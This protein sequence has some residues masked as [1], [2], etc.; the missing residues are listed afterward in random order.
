MGKDLR[1][2]VRMLRKSPGFTLMAVVALA[3]GIGANTA[4]FSIVNAVMLSR[5]PFEKPDRL[6]MVW[7]ASPSTN[8]TNVVNPL[9]FLEWQERNRS[10]ARIAA[11]APFLQ[12]SLSG[13]GEPEQ[14]D[15]MAVSSGFFEILGIQP[16][17]GRWFTPQEDTPGNDNVAILGEGLWR[18][19]YGADRGIVGH[20]IHVNNQAITVVGIMP[21]GFRFPMTKSV[22]WTPLGLDRKGATASRGRYLSTLARLRE[23][24]SVVTAQSDMN[25]I[26]SQLQKERPDFDSKW[27]ITVISLR[28]QVVGDVRKPLYI[29]LGAVGLVLM[30]ACANVANLMLMRAAGRGR[31]IAIRTALGAGRLRIVRQLLV[32]STLLSTAGGALGLVAGLWSMSALTA[33]LP[34]SIAYLNLKAIRL[35]GTV[36]LFTL[37]LS[38]V[39]G[40]LFGLAPAIKAARTDIQEALKS[41]GRGI[42]S[43]RSFTRSALVV[44]EVALSMILLVSAGLLIRSFARLAN[45]D[46][47]FDA[48]HVLTMHLA[49]AG[50]FPSDQK[51]AEFNLQVLQRVRAVPGVEAAGAA[52]FLPLGRIIPGT[53]FWRADHIRPAP[54]DAPVAEVLVVMPGYFAA[55]NIP[56]LQGRVF[57]DHDRAAQQPHL[58]VI[59]QTLAKQFYPNESPVGKRLSVQWGH[60]NDPYEIAGVVGDVHEKSLDADPKPGVFVA[61]L[62]EPNGFSNLVVRTHGDPK[63]LAQAIQRE[64]HALD[65]DIPISDVKTMDEDVAASVAAPRFNT[66]LLAG[67][68]GLALALSAVG[69]FGVISYSVAQRTQELG[70]RRA[71]GANSCSMMRLVLVE[72]LG[73]AGI[74]LAIG[75]AGA[76]AV[77]RLLE[78]LL[79]GVTAT[80]PL[81]FGVV[82]AILALVALLA[83]YLPARRAAA[84]D[85]IVALRYE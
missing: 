58:V 65:H 19:R 14:V 4:I 73:L 72:G 26:S 81:T 51:F 56:V 85:P 25:L 47:G 15:G 6:A 79:F 50:R 7:E 3:L 40:M 52:Q 75:L 77:T 32:E 57:D 69:I 41:G 33:A 84:V 13:D 60:P 67:F 37:G 36:F 11:F 74:G 55:M 45:V 10:F 66:I 62:Q 24:A 63:L 28:E 17:A 1:F 30:I 2:A 43:G 34:D 70:I 44:A 78:S 83:S 80:D 18:R 49:K 48:P 12:L 59:N 38:F 5:L 61:N 53:G 20:Q 9:N 68:A 8:K 31:E 22:Y 71:L 29:L 82:G 64:I 39:T 46:P 76:L 35:D 23:G 21:A 42:A 16:I 27:G 54:G